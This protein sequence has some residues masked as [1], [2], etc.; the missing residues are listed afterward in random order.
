MKYFKF[1]WLLFCVLAINGCMSSNIARDRMKEEIRREIMA[2]LQDREK[3]KQEILAELRVQQ[4]AETPEVVGPPAK[5]PAPVI[6]NKMKN[7]IDKEILTQLDSQPQPKSQS[8]SDRVGNAEGVILLRGKGIQ[9][10]K[11]KLVRMKK[12]FGMYLEVK[13]EEYKTLT[14]K[15]G[16]YRFNNLPEGSYKLKWELPGDSGWIRRLQD[17]PDVAIKRGSTITL[18]PIETAQGVLPF[19]RLD[20]GETQ[21]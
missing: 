17:K 9:S 10:C 4:A 3:L 8:R 13:E 12:T 14:D 11:V 15:D 2:E 7:E 21:D 1:G 5:T 16:K 19:L 6:S 20:R 18:E